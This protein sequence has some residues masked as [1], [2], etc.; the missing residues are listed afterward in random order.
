MVAHDSI[1]I[2]KHTVELDSHA[3]TCVIGEN[4]LVIL[5]HNRPVNVCNF[6]QKD[7][8]RCAKTV[9][10]A[11]CYQDLQS[12]QKYIL[13]INQAIHIN[14]LE[15]HLLCP[16]QCHLVGV[17]ISE[18]LKFLAESLS[19]ATYAIQFTYP[20]DTTHPL[21]IPLQLGSVTSYF[22]VH[23]L[24]IAEY[25]NEGI[26]QIHLTAEEPPWDPSTEEYSKHETCMLDHQGQISIPAIMAR[27][28]VF[29]SAVILYSLAYDVT[30]VM[31]DDNLA[32]A[33]LA[34]I[35]ISI[36]LIGMVIKPSVGPIVLAKQ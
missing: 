8:H 35:Q 12:R 2:S 10:A 4:C 15:S 13:M 6:D 20:F 29:V 21:I 36:A 1:A 17:H 18:I 22:D 7:G 27:G 9:D 14:G 23:S 28:P 19:V 33:L 31:D 11:I 26:P 30:D 3:D 24:N 34:H 25:G 32:T 16:V 5:D